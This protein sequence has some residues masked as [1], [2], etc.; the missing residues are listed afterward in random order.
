MILRHRDLYSV[1]NNGVVDLV[2]VEVDLPLEESIPTLASVPLSADLDIQSLHPI[3]VS[4]PIVPDNDTRPKHRSGKLFRFIAVPSVDH[5]LKMESS[6]SIDCTI[7]KSMK[8]SEPDYGVVFTVI[9]PGSISKKVMYE[10]TIS[11]FPTCTY[12]GF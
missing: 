6:F 4:S 9:T 10:V 3:G 8:V 2:L 11:D 12:R 5:I 7:L 1:L